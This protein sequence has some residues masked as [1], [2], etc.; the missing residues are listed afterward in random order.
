[1]RTRFG[2]TD[3]RQPHWRGALGN[4]GWPQAAMG[5]AIAQDHGKRL[6]KVFP[7]CKPFK[8]EKKN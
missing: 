2:Q 4:R 3:G 8:N 7:A 5:F 1:L 6:S